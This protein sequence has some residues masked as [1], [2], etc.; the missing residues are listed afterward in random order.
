MRLEPRD[1]APLGKGSFSPGYIQNY[2][3]ER[4][5]N[6]NLKISHF[7]PGIKRLDDPAPSAVAH[8]NAGIDTSP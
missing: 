3:P 7:L 2:V 6:R 8:P 1:N 4:S 5:T